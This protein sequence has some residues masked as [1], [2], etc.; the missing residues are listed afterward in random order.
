MG[1]YG[2]VL[3]SPS[4]INTKG[5]GMYD[6]E[7]HVDDDGFFE[8]S[9]SR[10]VWSPMR[11]LLKE[12]I[13]NLKISK[14]K[15]HMLLALKE[16]GVQEI[17]GSKHNPRVLVYHSHT[18]YKAKTDE[19]SWC[20]AFVNYIMATA[21]YK[22]TN[23][24][25]AN[26]WIGWG[27]KSN[28]PVY[29]AVVVVQNYNGSYHVGFYHSDAPKDNFLMLGGNQGKEGIGKVSKTYFEKSR[30]IYMGLPKN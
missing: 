10:Q 11:F 20:S 6:K 21:G 27:K 5:K 18:S 29:G 13:I 16:L 14:R 17:G 15:D 3:E 19:V 24:A 7:V 8:W 25:H 23:D 26:S 12:I 1:K 9:E 30:I 4:I 2:S 22:G 28:K